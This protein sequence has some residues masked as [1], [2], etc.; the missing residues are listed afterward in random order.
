MPA[1]WRWSESS[2]LNFSDLPNFETFLTQI[3]KEIV[4]NLY[5]MFKN[6]LNIF[7]QNYKCSSFETFWGLCRPHGSGFICL[8][9]LLI[10]IR[11][12]ESNNF[13]NSDPHTYQIRRKDLNEIWIILLIPKRIGYTILSETQ[14][15]ICYPHSSFIS[16]LFP[17][18]KFLLTYFV[19]ILIIEVKLSGP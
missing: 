2:K 7:I 17:E 3:I 15:L 8:N 16:L 5:F 19:T 13:A 9:L 4:W 11:M 14:I 18:T 10:R 6:I 12:N 1:L